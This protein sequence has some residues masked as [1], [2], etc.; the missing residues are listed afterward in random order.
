M[1]AVRRRGGA[2][3]CSSCPAT[4]ARTSRSARLRGRRSTRRATPPSTS[5]RSPAASAQRQTRLTAT[6]CSRRRRRSAPRR[7]GGA[8]GRGRRADCSWRTRWARW[9]PSRP[10]ARRPR[11]ACRCSPR[12]SALAAPL[13]RPPLACSASL[14]RVYAGL[15]EAARQPAMPTAAAV[16]SLWAPGDWRRASAPPTRTLRV[17][18]GALRARCAD[19]CASRR[20]GRRRPPV[21]PLVPAAR[22]RRS[23]ARS[24]RSRWR[25]RTKR[26]RR[27]L[28]VSERAALLRRAL[29]LAP[30]DA[31]DADDADDRRAVR[32]ARA[33]CGKVRRQR[34]AV[35]RLGAVRGARERGGRG[36][37]AALAA[38]LADAHAAGV[39]ARA[40][41]RRGACGCSCS[42]RRARRGAPRDA[43]CALR[44]SAAACIFLAALAYGGGARVTLGLTAAAAIERRRP[45]GGAPFCAAPRPLARRARRPQRRRRSWPSPSRRSRSRTALFGWRSPPSARS[46]QLER[47]RRRSPS[48]PRS[49]SCPRPRRVGPELR[50]AP[51]RVRGCEEMER[52]RAAPRLPPAAHAPA[53]RRAAPS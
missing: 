40:P 6:S 45:R 30:D 20:L 35:P 1:A 32:P 31:D 7:R 21:H 3:P 46:W 10:S 28:P 34:V 29:L 25:S 19:G 51:R 9:L 49:R 22:R 15:R 2:S 36:G 50:R 52:R 41:R 39:A 42:L 26:T 11:A 8:A 44:Y 24:P 18:A 14:D 27:R 16:A 48:L 4:A 5:T 38:R 17:A 12:R 33:L 43:I 47:R 37:E 23:R 13:R 53:R